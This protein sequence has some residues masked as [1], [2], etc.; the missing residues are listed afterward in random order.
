MH[1]HVYK[2]ILKD[3]QN[4]MKKVAIQLAGN[5]YRNNLKNPVGLVMGQLTSPIYS[6]IKKKSYIECLATT[7]KY[8]QNERYTK[9]LLI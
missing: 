2:Y 3:M 4:F 6:K 1:I 5:I 7:R 8:I 9:M